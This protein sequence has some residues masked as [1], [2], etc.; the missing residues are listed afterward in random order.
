MGQGPASSTGVARTRPRCFRTW[1]VRCSRCRP[2][3]SWRTARSSSWTNP[4]GPSSNGCR[5]GPCSRRPATSSVLPRSCRP[6]CSS[7]ICSRSTSSI[8]G[9]C[10]WS[11]ARSCSRSWFRRW[12]RSARSTTWKARAVRCTPACA[13][14][15]SRGW[16][17]SGRSPRTA[18]A[19]S[20]TGRRSAPITSARAEMEA[21]RL[22]KP[23]CIGPLPPGS[24]HTWVQPKLVVEV[25]YKE[26]TEEGLLRQPTFLR[27]RTDKS[28][29]ECVSPDAPP[30]SLAP[31]EVPFSNLEK[32]FWPEE[33]HTKGDLIAYYRAIAPWILPYLRDRPLVM[34]RYPDG[35]KGKSFFQ[36]DAPGFGPDWLRKERMWSE[37]GG[38]E[39]DYFVCDDEPSLLYVINLG[40][41]PLHVWSSRVGSLQRPD[42]C[43][44]DL[45]PKGAPFG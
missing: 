21:L 34:T 17:R 15:G 40:T 36:K 22:A 29:A 27:F 8:S 4:A 12:G 16:W 37:H 5:S 44:L 20:G 9:R 30:V 2:S 25:R 23:P 10:P 1:H 7:S 28:P 19:A 26:I 6:R 38:R 35:I 42:W 41:I 33:G 13:S 24:G 43:I 39:I 14:W 11:T 32:V 45:D 18:A 31:R 3:D